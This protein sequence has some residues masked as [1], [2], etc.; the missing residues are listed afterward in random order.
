MKSP[1]WLSSHVESLE[2]APFGRYRSD[3][4]VCNRKNTF[5]VTDDGVQRLWFCFHAD[6][7]VRG[8]T[9]IKISREHAS[10][11][12]KKRITPKVNSTSDFEIPDT[13]VSLSR[14]WEGVQYAR[15]VNSYDAYLSGRVDLR[16]DFKKNRVV[17]LVKDGSKVVDAVG[18][19]LTDRTPKW[20]RY[21]SSGNPFTCGNSTVAFVVEDCASAC[22]VS[23]L[24]EGV[25]L[26]GTNLLESHI[27]KLA[28][29]RK[30]FV[31]L[32]KDATDKAIQM[33]R[34]LSSR[35]PTRLV[36]LATDL[37][38]LSKETRDDFIRKYIT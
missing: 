9:S 24:V 29:Y 8:R 25:A 32:D 38:N 31:A 36:I 12:F 34:V 22:C 35:V 5:S 28:N 6:C 11:A 27:E 20:Y 23:D 10:Q 21:G 14:S 7:N 13:F 33:V 19:S 16:Y 1:N 15:K 18:R 26:L 30:V 37:K 4:P 17:F 3:C 2:I